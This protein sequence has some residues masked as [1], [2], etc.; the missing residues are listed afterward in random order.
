[1]TWE[2]WI[3]RSAQF[4]DLLTPAALARF[5][6][7]L[8]HL[9]DMQGNAPAAPQ[10]IHWCLCLPDAPT[11]QLG[12]DG[13][14]RRDDS[15]DSFMP[16][17]P[18][19]RRMWA[20]SNVHFHAPIS[21][22]AAIDRTSTIASITEKNGSTGQLFFVEVANDTMA[23]G[24]LAVRETQSIVFR[25]PAPIIKPVPTIP[26]AP[27]SAP[28]L[29]SWQWQRKVTPY[30]AML[31]R[32]SALTFNS[33]RIHY[34]TPYAQHEEGYPDLV[35]HGPLTATLLLDLAQRQLGINAL[36]HFQ[37]RAIS[38][39]FVNQDLYLVGKPAEDGGWT[40]AALGPDGRTI[41]TAKA[42]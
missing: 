34:D 40:L 42:G 20:A 21:A 19:P 14:P 15:P 31:F 29:S 25:A 37:M 5:C 6:A 41:M 23:D 38:P 7:T 3:G 8:D 16:P 1:M 18:L 28:D 36:K 12:T 32:Y 24:A 10:G 33:H 4:R 2:N 30:A 35:V 39:A 13:H 17:L 27:A 11:A 9:W 26:A 22:G